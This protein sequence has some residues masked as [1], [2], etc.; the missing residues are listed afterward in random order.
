MLHG[1]TSRTPILTYHDIIPKRDSKSLWFDCSVQELKDQLNWLSKHGAHFVTVREIYNHLTGNAPL[2][3]KAICITFADNYEG[4]W[5]YGYPILKAHS[6]P[7]AMFVH[8]GY[9]GDVKHGRPKMTWAQL[10][11]L[12]KEGLVTIGS[13][14]VSH[15]ADLTKL[16]DTAL[17]REMSQSKSDL[18]S[19]LG[20]AIPLLAYPNGKFDVRCE[21]AARKAGYIAAFCEIQKPCELSA[22]IFAINRYVHTKY[23]QAW[24][25]AYK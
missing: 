21:R 25:D 9:V 14:T 11:Q 12:D 22:S 5:R 16:D 18:E 4:F 6:V 3:K 15:P 24:F 19:H 10:K 1:L 13:Q 8:T 23:R 17:A 7:V 20:H 2:P